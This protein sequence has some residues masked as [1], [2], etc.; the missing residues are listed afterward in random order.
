[1]LYI[2]KIDQAQ[3]GTSYYHHGAG[4]IDNKDPDRATR[5]FNYGEAARQAA[6]LLRPGG[7]LQGPA[8]I[9]FEPAPES[10]PD[11]PWTVEEILAREG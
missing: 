2:I 11:R 4:G 8:A 5:F 1:M 6:E 9:T 7:G 3:Q 10:L